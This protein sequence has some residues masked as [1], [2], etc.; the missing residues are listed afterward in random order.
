MGLHRTRARTSSEGRLCVTRPR[1][2]EGRHMVVLAGRGC[3]G[4]RVAGLVGRGGVVREPSVRC[5]LE[6][7]AVRIRGRKRKKKLTEGCHL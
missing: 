1:D 6:T 5:W 3:M 2:Q 7:K 4:W